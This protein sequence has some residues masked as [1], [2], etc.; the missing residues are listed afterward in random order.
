MNG[1]ADQRF[2]W[3]I[4]A[5]VS[6]PATFLQ[7]HV[8]ETLA[9][10]ELFYDTGLFPNQDWQEKPREGAWVAEEEQVLDE[11]TRFEGIVEFV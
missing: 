3:N 7:L 6:F 4:W 8:F 2:P 1:V 5:A 9:Y 10:S 11:K